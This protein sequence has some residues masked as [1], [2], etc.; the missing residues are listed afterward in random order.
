MLRKVGLCKSVNPLSFLINGTVKAWLGRHF[1]APESGFFINSDRRRIFRKQECRPVAQTHKISDQFA[2]KSPAL[3]FFGSFHQIKAIHTER[4]FDQHG[5][6]CRLIFKKSA[7]KAAVFTLND[8]AQ[9]RSAAVYRIRIFCQIS[10]IKIIQ[11]FF[12]Y[13]VFAF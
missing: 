11:Q 1:D 4:R 13:I 8:P 2:R 5:D 6:T 12:G 9:Q 10:V 3:K 7:E